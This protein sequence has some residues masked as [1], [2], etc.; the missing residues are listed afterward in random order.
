MTETMAEA[1]AGRAKG[2]AGGSDI[3]LLEL[4]ALHVDGVV[5]QFRLRADGSACFPYVSDNV[6]KFF[7]LVAAEIYADARRLLAQIPPS[8]VDRLQAS[9]RQACR[10]LSCWKHQF[11]T[12]RGQR[13]GRWL[14]VYALP[15]READGATLWYGVVT[16][17]T[18]RRMHD[19]QVLQMAYYD[20][21]TCLPNRRLLTE[22]LTQ[23]IADSRRQSAYSA[24]LFLDLDNFKRLNDGHGH[25]VGDLLLIEAATRLKK[26][27]R[28][29][30]TVARL[31]GD[32]FVVILRVLHAE[33]EK[34]AELAGLIAEKIRGALSTACRLTFRHGDG[35]E[36][37]I[38]H[39]NTAS[40][41]ITLF[42]DHDSS[43]AD[44]LRRAD[45]AMYQAKEAGRDAIRYCE[46]SV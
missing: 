45:R 46:Q 11:Q 40:I 17:V 7:P 33:K 25:A 15:R 29:M 13:D 20:A 14:Q 2:M 35:E 31:G 38:E 30:D 22:R 6:G 12:I 27:V 32:E 5:F 39:H 1:A 42:R 10:A 26:V 3:D 19:E 36:V 28:E 41:G 18:E 4:I 9:I 21:L 37:T 24:L 43:H 8:V 44:I 23:A 16:D 34:A